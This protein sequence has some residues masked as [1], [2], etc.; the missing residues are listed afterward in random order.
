[1]RTSSRSRR[2]HHLSSKA[3]TIDARLEATLAELD[4]IKARIA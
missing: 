4:D 3:A 2:R 1:V